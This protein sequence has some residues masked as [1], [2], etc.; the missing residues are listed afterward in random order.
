MVFFDCMIV[1][2]WIISTDPHKY[3]IM[4]PVHTNNITLNWG[5]IFYNNLHDRASE[6]KNYQ[7]TWRKVDG[8]V[9]HPGH[10]AGVINN[11]SFII[12]GLIPGNK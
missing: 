6:T 5:D 4:G 9:G 11:L 7:I 3:L 12:K 8:Q 10:E 2:I 1:P